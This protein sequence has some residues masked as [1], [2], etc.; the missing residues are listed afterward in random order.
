[1][2]G[3]KARG[4]GGAVKEGVFKCL[5]VDLKYDLTKNLSHRVAWRSR[6]GKE[7]EE[8]RMSEGPVERMVIGDGAVAF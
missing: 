5:R 6:K 2:T 7:G 1:V 3:T 4:E 8:K